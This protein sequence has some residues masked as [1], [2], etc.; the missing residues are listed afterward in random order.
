MDGNE[1]FLLIVSVDPME[2]T[3][4]ALNEDILPKGGQNNEW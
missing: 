1:S 4:D 3:G 2:P